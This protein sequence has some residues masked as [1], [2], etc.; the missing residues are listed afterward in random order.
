MSNSGPSQVLIVRHGEKLGDPSDDK[1]GGSDLSI[2]GSAR[3]AALPLLFVPATPEFSCALAPGNSETFTGIYNEVNLSG[4]K[5]RFQ[6]PNFLVAT[7]ASKSSNRPV[8]TITPL[9]LALSLSIN[10]SYSDSQY[11]VLA[12]AILTDSQYA[13][14]VVLICW[15]HGTIPD[16]ASALGASD[17]PQKWPSAV[18]DRVW[19]IN[20]QNEGAGPL[21]NL[22]QELLYADAGS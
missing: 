13:G 8:E 9:S 6:T 14:Q 12:T 18:F 17:V 5:P 10:G 11:A 7:A 15:H 20:Y 4:N 16:L 22:P 21:Q 19:Q 3:A 2:K 1:I